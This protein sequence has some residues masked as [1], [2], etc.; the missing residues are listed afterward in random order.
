MVTEAGANLRTTPR[1]TDAPSPDEQSAPAKTE[2]R[3]SPPRLRRKGLLGIGVAIIAVAGIAGAWLFTTT[4]DTRA[5]LAMAQTVSRGEVISESDLTSAN[6]SV[7]PALN[8]VA[9]E[10]ADQV[11]GFRAVTDLPAGGIVTTDS[12]TD[13]IPPASGE[14]LVGIAV[15]PR[16]LPNE[17]LLPGDSV[18]IVDTPR[19]QDDPPETEPQ[20]TVATVVS[21]SG[22]DDTGHVVVDVTV[23]SGQAAMLA[24]RAATGRIDLV[25]LPREGN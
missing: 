12:V 10:N 14:E 24:A 7:D 8:P 25:L 11:I 4:T 22:L 6:I 1:S 3:P 5:V 21:V 20:S 18:R 17:P 15:T 9:A 23:S 19:E 16:Q 2:T 13:Q